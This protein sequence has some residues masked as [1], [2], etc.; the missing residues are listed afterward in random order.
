MSGPAAAVVEERHVAR[1][2]V[3]APLIDVIRAP[4]INEI[5]K[6]AQAGETA[7]T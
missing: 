5:V 4:E 3:G 2:S 7:T 6:R 1:W